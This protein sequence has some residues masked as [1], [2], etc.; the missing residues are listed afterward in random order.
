MESM[1]FIIVVLFILGGILTGLLAYI[2][3]FLVYAESK[4]TRIIG[5]FIG[6]AFSVILFHIIT[7]VIWGDIEILINRLSELE[8]GKPYIVTLIVSITGYTLLT[9]GW[10][11]PPVLGFYVGGKRKRKRTAEK[12]HSQKPKGFN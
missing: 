3:G 1:F 8:F 11:A 2:L 4:T 12:L 5:K 10:L 6:L 7:I 9:I